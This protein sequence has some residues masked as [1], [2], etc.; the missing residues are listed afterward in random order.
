M[1]I[2]SAA[3]TFNYNT[4]CLALSAE[5][6]ALPS[7]FTAGATLGVEFR[8]GSGF[9]SKTDTD[10]TKF[11]TGSTRFSFLHLLSIYFLLAC[12]IRS[13]P[14]FGRRPAIKLLSLRSSFSF[15]LSEFSAPS[16]AHHSRR[17]I[18]IAPRRFSVGTGSCFF[19]FSAKLVQPK[20]VLFTKFQF[21]LNRHH[22][23]HY[24]YLALA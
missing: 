2:A 3:A 6:K 5:Q 4:V 14:R 17:P 7:V 8:R 21:P 15:F 19:L 20:M 11:P 13:G 16:S 24:S 10:Y 22:L 23:A 9:S 12:F 18:A 1:N